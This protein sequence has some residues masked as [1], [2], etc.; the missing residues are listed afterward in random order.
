MRDRLADVQ[1]VHV[2]DGDKS[3]AEQQYELLNTAPIV[4]GGGGYTSGQARSLLRGGLVD[5]AAAAALHSKMLTLCTKP[6]LAYLSSRFPGTVLHRGAVVIRPLADGE[7]S[8]SVTPYVD[9]SVL[10]LVSHALQDAL[11]AVA[12]AV[13]FL[14][15]STASSRLSRRRRKRTEGTVESVAHVIVAIRLLLIVQRTTGRV[16]H[17]SWHLDEQGFETAG[18]MAMLALQFVIAHELAHIAHGHISSADSTQVEVGH[19]N[20]S[21]TQELQ[22]DVLAFRLLKDIL[23]TEGEP[24]PETQAMWGAF[25]ALIAM[26]VTENSLYARRNS[27]HPEPVHRWGMVEY[28]AD[29]QPKADI[30][31]LRALAITAVV[32]ASRLHK[33][34]TVDRW[35]LL[36]GSQHL[37]LDPVVN[38]AE[39]MEIDRLNG[40]P[41]SVLVPM[42]REVSSAIGKEVIS[43]LEGGQLAAA[44][45][46]LGVSQRRIIALLDGRNAITFYTLKNMIGASPKGS[47]MS[48]NILLFSITC[49]RLAC[50]LLPGRP[51]TNV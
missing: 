3:L 13:I 48:D 46:L 27:T 38:I 49:A 32:G 43:R 21:I 17:P 47:A 16:I 37:R 10:L 34:L 8:A 39:I 22:A 42:A 25:L 23:E 29:V 2:A 36:H 44:M 18:Q 40:T 30:K 51:G 50:E 24:D 7:S 26:E 35:S 4:G 11:I 5:P 6:I 19:V 9:Q 31:E 33:P 15:A 1:T 12:N 14:D 28:L 20:Q 45:D 41:L